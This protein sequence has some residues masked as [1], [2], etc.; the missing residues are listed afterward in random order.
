MCIQRKLIKNLILILFISKYICLC[1]LLI[2]IP[3]YLY[4]LPVLIAV[5]YTHFP[6][7]SYYGCL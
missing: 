4:L 5:S 2:I 1:K 3:S 7:C 6:D